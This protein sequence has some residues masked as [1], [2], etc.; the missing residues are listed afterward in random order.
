MR[1]LDLTI[2]INKI[3]YRPAKNYIQYVQRGHRGKYYFTV[4]IK[5]ISVENIE[6]RISQLQ[7]S[8]IFVKKKKSIIDKL[9]NIKIIIII[10]V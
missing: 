10:N 1:N 3:R 7:L 8:K 4:Y 6:M 2:S 5:S 9:K